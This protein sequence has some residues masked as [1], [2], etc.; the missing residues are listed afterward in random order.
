MP[1]GANFS[2]RE[3]PISESHDMVVWSC[4]NHVTLPLDVVF[5][6]FQFLVLAPPFGVHIVN[7]HPCLSMREE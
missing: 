7:K 4:D 3:Q 2:D 6:S 1:V 5:F